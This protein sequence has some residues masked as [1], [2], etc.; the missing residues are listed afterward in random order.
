M[1]AL[2]AL[3]A[4]VATTASSAYGRLLS[5]NTSDPLTAIATQR[6]SVF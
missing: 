2:P 1:S 5:V 6:V 3:D 4:S